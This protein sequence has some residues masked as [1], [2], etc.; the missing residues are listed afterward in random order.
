MTLNLERIGHVVF[1]KLIKIVQLL[2]HDA[3]RTMTDENQLH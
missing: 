1:K 3:Y 2:T